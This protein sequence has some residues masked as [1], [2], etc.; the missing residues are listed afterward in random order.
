MYVADR[1]TVPPSAWSLEP[2]VGEDGTTWRCRR[3]PLA[4]LPRARAGPPLDR[5]SRLTLSKG[6]LGQA[7]AARRGDQGEEVLA[8]R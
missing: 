4:P 5:E 7:D 3:S 2:S 1:L 6:F 8:H